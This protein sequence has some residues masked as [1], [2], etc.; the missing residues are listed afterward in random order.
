MNLRIA[1]YIIAALCLLL[2]G[3]YLSYQAKQRRPTPAPLAGNHSE[4][5]A[6]PGEAPANPP[7]TSSGESPPAWPTSGELLTEDD[8]PALPA[9]IQDLLADPGW[10]QPY[11]IPT[12]A[13]AE[14]ANAGQAAGQAAGPY[15]VN[16]LV[17]A[18]LSADRTTYELEPQRDE[19]GSF[20]DVALHAQLAPNSAG[21]YPAVEACVW[22][23]RDGTIQ[24]FEGG[25]E[26]EML[27]TTH[28][29]DL[30][31]TQVR[32]YIVRLLVV[33]SEGGRSYT[34]SLPIKIGAE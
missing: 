1:G 9:E 29:Y 11:I 19:A 25:A 20:A 14:A 13:P 17:D 34:D 27:N 23:F 18:P 22:A 2:V 28:R 5:V 6:T 30:T 32:V 15:R 12:F 24:Y 31:D 7:A 4:P 33:D 10:N 3:F 26:A 21:R 16:L 8:L